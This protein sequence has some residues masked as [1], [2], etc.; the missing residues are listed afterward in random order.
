MSDFQKRIE[1]LSPKRL[2]LLA[3]E[4]QSQVEK[5]ERQ[6]TEPIAV[7]G[8]GCRIPGA[9]EGPDAFWRLLQEGRS[10]I[11]EV[12]GDRWK[13]EAY[14]DGNIDAPGRMCTK[15]GGFLSHID[16][17]DAP[18]FSIAGREANGMDPQHRILLEVCWEAVEHA[19][20][21]PRKL[22]GTATGVFV[23]ICASDYQTMLLA[24]GE[25]A[26][27]GYLASGT[28]PSI[29]AGRISYTLGLQGPSMAIDTACSASLV[30]VHLACQS[31]RTR[32]CSMALAGGVNAILS[33]TTTI[34]LSKAHMMAPDGLCKSFDSRAD[35]FVRSEGCG[36]VVLKR[37]SDAVADGDHILALIRGSAV[38]QDGRS[39][40]MTAPNGM[41]QEGVIRSA[42][43]QA[44]VQPEEIGYVEA[45]GTGTSLGDPIEAHALAEVLG[46]GRGAENPLVVGSVK[47]NLGHME[48][49]AGIVGLIKTVLALKQQQIPAHLHFQQMNPHIDWG[50]VP[51][52]IPLAGRPWPR[53]KRRRLA[54]VSSF[55]FSGTNAHMIVEEAPAAGERKRGL[56][57]GQHLLALSARSK[58]ALRQLAERYAAE[59]ALGEVDLGD[60]CYTANAGR[61]HFEQRLAVI[62]STREEVRRRLLDASLGEPERAR[63]RVRTAFLFPGQGAQYAGMGKE[64]YETQPVFRATLEECAEY[65]RGELD[66]P[67]LE[68]LWGSAAKWLDETVYTQPA[69]FAVEYGL[70]RLWQSWGIEPGWVVGHSVGEYVAACVAGVYSLAE[71]LK[72]IAGRGRLMQGVSG[73]GGMAALWAGEDRVREAL[74]GLEERV[75]IAALNGPESVVI[76]GYTEELGRVE[77]RL[78]DE[79]I[80]VQRLRGSHGF[81]SPQMREMEEA[82]EALAAE[83]RFVRPRLPVIS[84]VTG[85]PVGPEEMSHAGYW[86]RQV[87]QPVRFRQAMESLRDQGGEVFLEVGPG[88]TLGLLGQES[89]GEA[90]QLWLS[91]LRRGRGEWEQ[92]LESLGRLYTR[93]AEVNW[94]AFDEP[95]ARR[96]VPLPTYPFERQSYWMDRAHLRRTPESAPEGAREIRDQAP[97]DIPPADWYYEVSWQPRAAGR[98][99]GFPGGTAAMERDRVALWRWLIVSDGSDLA[100]ELATQI[101][102]LGGKA[103]LATLP[104][105]AGAELRNGAYDLVLHLASSTADA[106]AQADRE[107]GLSIADEGECLSRALGTAQAVL[108]EEHGARLW[109]VTAGAQFAAAPQSALNLAQ[110]PLWGFGKTFALEHP[111]SWGGLVDL[112]PTACASQSATELLSAIEKDDGEDQVAFRDGQRYVARLT[113]AVAPS[114]ATQSFAPDKTYLITGGLGGLGLKAAAWM[115]S[116]GARNLVLVGRKAPSQEALGVIEDLQR[117]GVRVDVYAADVGSM[118]QIEEIFRKVQDTRPIIGGIIHAA[119]VL[120]DGI[121]AQQTWERFQKVMLPKVAGAWNLHRLTAGMPLEFFVLFSSAASLMGSTGQAS[122]A[123]ANAYLDALAVNRKAAGLPALSI[124]W[125]GWAEAGMAARVVAQGRRQTELQ[126]MPPDLALAALGQVLLTG[127]AQIGIAAVDW[128]VHQSLNGSQPFLKD[129]MTETTAVNVVGRDAGQPAKQRLRELLRALPNERGTRLVQYL[130]ETLAPT[131]GV[132]ART[133]DPFKPVTDYGLDSLMALEFRNRINSD[134]EVAIPTVRFLQGFSLEEV[135]AQ[136]E[137]E[138]PKAEVRESEATISGSMIEFPLSFGQQVQWFGHKIMAGSASYNV[139][140]TAKACPCLDWPTFERAVEKLTARHAALRTIFFANDAG[141]PMQRI[142]QSPRPDAGLVEASSWSDNEI[143]EAILQDF[144]RPFTLDRPMFRVTVFRGEDGDVVFFKLDHIIIDHWSVRLCIEDLR[145]IYVAELA[146]T[147]PALEPVGA[148][149]AE[150]VEWES[151]A[152]QGGGS[153]ELWEYWKRK[154]GGELPLLRLPST[155]QRPAVLISRGEALPL[156]LTPEHWLGVLRIAREYRATGYS[157][158]L[159]AFQV[160]LYHY[161]GQTDIIVGTSVSGRENPRWTNTMGLFINLLALRGNLA[162][163]PTF[164]EYLV[165]TRDTVL[166]ALEH[167]EFPFA[168]LAT[169]LR[170][171]RNLERTRI[172]QS[173]FNFLTDRSGAL[174]SLFM[175]V[176]AGAVEFGASM[177]HPY[178]VVPQQEGRP[179][180]GVQLAEMNGQLVGYLNYN[181]DVL[182]PETAEAMATDYCRLLDVIIRDP[183]TPIDD[184]LPGASGEASD[185]EEILL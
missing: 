32:E 104:D 165:R 28:A 175:G 147:E 132:E 134:L 10:S 149:Y 61:A 82:F 88:A 17:F 41:A 163:N 119:G 42:L 103:T 95:Y 161:T 55:G 106:S 11:G 81:H 29:A 96:R 40:G 5:M 18:F 98:D 141:A 90:G 12:P 112:D 30:A 125:G 16:Q 138:L 146:G 78:R 180:V 76:S 159:A 105:A 164:T 77:D 114:G 183:N 171:P 45:H 52:E 179:E 68:V 136:I 60:L 182:D 167:Q 169:R 158:L 48:S 86:R 108:A 116:H 110:A 109:I 51:V 117:G 166:E 54:G 124:N 19:G 113:R 25:N 26:I 34:A 74:R 137:A 87:S 157:F 9:E 170:Q 50:N 97:K 83:V 121:I 92:T 176:H 130:V 75:V 133:I 145:Q 63:A 4:L 155:R 47:T 122:Y 94:P 33:P 7:I 135:A 111:G 107:K 178:M 150:F 151:K 23:G 57:R 70:A 123:A 100:S 85:Q 53:G 49:A 38:N 22:A 101:R 84:S 79:G 126:L 58:G 46:A 66:R 148:E 127:A 39:S 144:Q 129:L 152:V 91:S 6:Q 31:L 37:L 93:G 162:G 2:M 153:D 72:L 44:G 177:L 185:R 168:L 67:L 160:L 27:D 13:A 131:L 73:L 59:L 14:Y 173:F 43:A 89:L 154:L 99:P 120:D 24:R 21:S 15:W 115:A 8:L 102:G 143:K 118:P 156:A 139:G 184:L 36:I 65:L 128:T 142:L 64:L 181:C 80:R 56:E 140:L 20:H 3:L 35:G 62:G 69:L 71:G 174:R 1:S 172:F